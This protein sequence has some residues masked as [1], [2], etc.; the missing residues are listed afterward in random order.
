MQIALKESKDDIP[1]CVMQVC[2]LE[3]VAAVVRSEQV[4]SE[5]GRQIC[6]HIASPAGTHRPV[7]TSIF[8]EVR[9]PAEPL[10]IL[11]PCVCSI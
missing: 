2:R 7:T 5:L 8:V 3:W 6:N 4:G 10:I 1:V 11:Y 9:P